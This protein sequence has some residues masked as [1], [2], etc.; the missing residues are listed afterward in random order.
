MKTILFLLLALIGSE[1][2]AVEGL[3]SIDS[4]YGVKETTD[5]LEKTVTKAGFTIAV[6]WNHAKGAEKVGLKLPPE[7][8]LI[9]GKPK[10]G[11]LLMQ[12][13]PTAGIDLPMKYLV[14]EDAQGK[15]HVAWNDPAWIAKR[16]GITDR[17]KLIAKMQG[18]LRKLAEKG[19]AP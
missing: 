5:R 3:V 16:H 12:S 6:R 10:A 13:S 11:T 17:A 15:V 7:E 19:V 18:V 14:W 4:P 2:F 9:F 8:I 1:A